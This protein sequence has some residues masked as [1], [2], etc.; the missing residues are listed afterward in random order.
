MTYAEDGHHIM[1]Q[2]NLMKFMGRGLLQMGTSFL[3]QLPKEWE[4]NIDVEAFLG[5]MSFKQKDSNERLALENWEMAP[6][7]G[8]ADYA[9]IGKFCYP[10]VCFLVSYTLIDPSCRPS[11]L[12]AAQQWEDHCQEASRFIP[13][14]G[15][16]LQAGSSTPDREEAEA[17]SEEGKKQI[18]KASS[19]AIGTNSFHSVVAHDLH[20]YSRSSHSQN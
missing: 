17:E 20:F 19:T 15:R 16:F 5:S 13:A 11:R 7:V 8:T 10:N 18:A 1:D 14:V 2:E 12:Q 9:N 4:I 6:Q 3:R